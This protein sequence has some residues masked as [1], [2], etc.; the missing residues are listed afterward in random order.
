MNFAHKDS[1][2]HS[3]LY[4]LKGRKIAVTHVSPELTISFESE[5]EAVLDTSSNE[6]ALLLSHGGRI[7]A[8]GANLRRSGNGIA[9]DV[10][11]GKR[12][13]LSILSE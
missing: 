4:A 1:H 8:S 9:L 7:I 13:F 5:V 11:S 3:L 6:V 12:L 2:H 10:G